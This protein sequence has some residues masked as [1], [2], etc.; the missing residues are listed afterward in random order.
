MFQVNRVFL[1]TFIIKGDIPWKGLKSDIYYTQSL[2]PNWIRSLPSIYIQNLNYL[3]L[4][5]LQNLTII[6]IQ[7]LH[8]IQTQSSSSVHICFHQRT[9]SIISARMWTL[10]E[11]NSHRIFPQHESWENGKNWNKLNSY[12][13]ATTNLITWK[14]KISFSSTRMIIL[15]EFHWN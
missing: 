5:Y 1:W 12:N 6:C 9:F 13:S 11:K 14:C 7:N 3:A 4:N 8:V 15:Y 2:P 10:S